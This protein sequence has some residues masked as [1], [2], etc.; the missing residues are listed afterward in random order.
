VGQVADRADGPRSAA[1][2]DPDQYRCGVPAPEPAAAVPDAAAAVPDVV[3][4]VDRNPELRELAATWL[5][6]TGF[7]VR[8]AADGG[9]ALRIV[10]DTAV[11][12]VVLD[13]PL[14]VGPTAAEVLSA[15][16]GRQPAARTVVTSVLDL[17]DYP[18][19]DAGLPKPFTRA[20]L[21]AAVAA[22]AV[23]LPGPRDSAV[24]GGLPMDGGS[25]QRA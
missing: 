23:A 14:P 11:S 12:A 4:V 3:L 20:Q 24:R 10:A 6:M 8:T 5:R 16:R 25:A 18:P 17:Q 9:A 2:G 7:D 22:S 21:V 1:A 15:I 13:H 19:A